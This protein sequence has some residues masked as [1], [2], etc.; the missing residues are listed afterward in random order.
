[1]LLDDIFAIYDAILERRIWRNS[2]KFIRN[3]SSLHIECKHRD[4]LKWFYH[5]IPIS[6]AIS[7]ILFEKNDYKHLQISFLETGNSVDG[8]ASV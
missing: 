4:D 3:I 5:I 8:V 7:I 1:M 2:I 6:M